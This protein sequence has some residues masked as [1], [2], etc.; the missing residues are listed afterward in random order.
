MYISEILFDLDRGWLGY[1][2]PDG[3]YV[4]YYRTFVDRYG[5]RRLPLECSTMGL[6]CIP[7][8]IP[9]CAGCAYHMIT[10]A[11]IV[12]PLHYNRRIYAE[13]VEPRISAG[14]LLR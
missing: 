9:Q 10:Q 12:T 7:F 5:N 8:I 2:D 1:L 3:G 6:D 4:D 11:G 13:L 14:S